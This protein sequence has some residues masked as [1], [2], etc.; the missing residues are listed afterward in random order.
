[1]AG[2]RC[3]ASLRVSHFLGFE[4]DDPFTF[5]YR[6]DGKPTALSGRNQ[7]DFIAASLLKRGQQRQHAVKQADVMLMRHVVMAS[8]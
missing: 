2:R 6:D 1:M 3:G 7:F 4:L 5:F 8:D